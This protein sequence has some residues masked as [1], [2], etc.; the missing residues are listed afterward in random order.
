MPDIHSS[1]KTVVKQGGLSRI[2]VRV[3]LSLMRDCDSKLIMEGIPRLRHALGISANVGS[4]VNL[5]QCGAV[6]AKLLRIVTYVLV[7]VVCLLMSL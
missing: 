1:K 6:L 5:T 4:K 3:T 2:A 7:P